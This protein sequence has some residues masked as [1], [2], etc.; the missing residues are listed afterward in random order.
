MATIVVTPHFA[1]G[2]MTC[3]GPAKTFTATV[4]PTAEKLNSRINQVVCNGEQNTTV[5]FANHHRRCQQL[6]LGQTSEPSIGL[7]AAASGNIPAFT[8]VKPW[9]CTW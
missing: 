8:A 6:Y 3:D 7:A 9:Y 5:N 2:G 4:N 1:N